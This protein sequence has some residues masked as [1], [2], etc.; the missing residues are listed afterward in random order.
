MSLPN[1]Q[2]LYSALGCLVNARVVGLSSSH[3]NL[4]IMRFED[5]SVFSLASSSV[6]APQQIDLTTLPVRVGTLPVRVKQ[7]TGK[8]VEVLVLQDFY[9]EELKRAVEMEYHTPSSQQQYTY[10]GTRL[11][12]GTKLSAYNIDFANAVFVQVLLLRGNT[13]ISELAIDDAFLSSRF[14]Y[15]FRGITDVGHSYIRGGLPYR[16]PVGYMRYAIN[17]LGKFDNGNDTWLAQNGS[18][19]EWAVSYHGSEVSKTQNNLMDDVL[20]WGK[21]LGL[22]NNNA[23][24]TFCT[25]NVETAVKFSKQNTDKNGCKS[26]LVF[27]N[28]VKPSSILKASS[29][30]GPDDYWYVKDPADIR[31]YSICVKQV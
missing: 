8:V 4:P 20:M 19:G 5:Y 15:D 24:M 9:I 23:N 29:V 14:N 31:V 25:P 28:R 30:G 11:L 18:A 7:L 10:N 17:V 27:Q 22:S 21:K 13:Q 12:N 16:R 2:L 6:T 1:D 3:P 26:I